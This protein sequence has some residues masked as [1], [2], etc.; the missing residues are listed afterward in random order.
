[1]SKLSFGKEN[2]VGNEY[3]A[4]VTALF[5]SSGMKRV[6]SDFIKESCGTI[7]PVSVLHDFT[8]HRVLVVCTDTKNHRY[9]TSKS[10]FANENESNFYWTANVAPEEVWGNMMMQGDV[11]EQKREGDEKIT[12][13]LL[14]TYQY[15]PKK[16]W[17]IFDAQGKSI[18]YFEKKIYLDT[19]ISI[20]DIELEDPEWFGEVLNSDVCWVV[21]ITFDPDKAFDFNI[22]NDE[23]DDVITLYANYRKGKPAQLFL[24]YLTN[25]GEWDAEVCLN[26]NQQR[27]LDAKVATAYETFYKEEKASVEA[28]NG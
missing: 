7:A 3:V 4:K 22:C 19:S 21:P 2:V 8:H 16:G 14:F 17:F 24:N 9:I 11:I 13:K 12:K 1:M 10:A 26:A 15:S 28:D 20:N 23:C 25:D 18:A 5:E 6:L 27:L